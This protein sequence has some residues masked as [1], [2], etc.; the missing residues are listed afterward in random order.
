MNPSLAIRPRLV[1]LA[2]AVLVVVCAF[3]SMGGAR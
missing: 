1:A 3:L 2:V